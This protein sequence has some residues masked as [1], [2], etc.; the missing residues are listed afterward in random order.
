M[1]GTLNFKYEVEVAN[2][3][4]GQGITIT[5]IQMIQALTTISNDGI[6]IKPYIVDKIVNTNNNE[7]V[8]N[9]T[10]KE[11]EESYQQIP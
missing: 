9:G 8:Y 4:F 2:A 11:L 7:I 6:M 5:P 3:G 10:R 1:S